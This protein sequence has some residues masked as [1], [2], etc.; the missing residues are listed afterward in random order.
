MNSFP[1][2]DVSSIIGHIYPPINPIN[3]ALIDRIREERGK[4]TR[5]LDDAVLLL[6]TF[7]LNLSSIT[8]NFN[9]S[10]EQSL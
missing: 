2:T 7:K 6:Q 10:H 1:R 9:A 3:I 4:A 8:R 5:R